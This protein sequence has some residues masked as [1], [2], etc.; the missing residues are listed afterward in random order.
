MLLS[1]TS[2]CLD[3]A[4]SRP[5]QTWVALSFLSSHHYRTFNSSPPYSPSTFSFHLLSCVS[6]SSSLPQRPH[7]VSSRLT[8]DGCDDDFRSSAS[9]ALYPYQHYE[10]WI[11]LVLIFLLFF[12][13]AFFSLFSS[14]ISPTRAFWSNRCGH[15]RVWFR[16]DSK[17]VSDTPC[18]RNFRRAYSLNIQTLKPFI[19]QRFGDS[20]SRTRVRKFQALVRTVVVEGK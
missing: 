6:S 7:L 8:S 9:L 13:H 19:L 11:F 3:A 5:N 12:C 15:S 17:W 16:F 4:R 1:L 18:Y 10:R 14:S 20:V 2:S